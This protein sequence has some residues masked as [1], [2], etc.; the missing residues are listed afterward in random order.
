MPD[1]LRDWVI[2][3]TLRNQAQRRP[4]AVYVELTDGRRTTYGEI[5]VVADRIATAL[6]TLGVGPGE[7]VGVMLRN[8]L[9]FLQCWLGIV[10]L[11]AV[12]VPVNVAFKGDFLEFVI[13]DS[14]ASV[15]V[16]ADEFVPTIE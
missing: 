16:T 8:S 13:N 6:Q 9:E 15:L 7:R 5:D 4:D 11:G 10:R 2:G 14:G 12:I 3:P 1:I